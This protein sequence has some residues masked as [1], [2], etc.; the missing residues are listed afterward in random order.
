YAIVMAVF[1]R[2]IS[3]LSLLVAG[4]TALSLQAQ[5]VDPDARLSAL[6]DGYC[7]DCHNFEDWAGGLAFEG[8]TADRIHGDA[9]VWETALRKLRGNLMPPPGN[10]QPGQQEIDAFTAFMEDTLDSAA[11]L[12]RAGHV[13][14]QRL[15]R[16]EY[17]SAV[18]GLIGVDIDA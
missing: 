16:Y 18:K 9:D 13:P 3:T 11:D 10:P 8:M 6:V 12:P 14:L 2:T 7:M 15:N 5:P 1:S 17:S 4:S